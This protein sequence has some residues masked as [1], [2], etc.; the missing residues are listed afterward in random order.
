MAFKGI[1]APP[2][3]GFPAL[4]RARERNLPGMGGRRHQE[5]EVPGGNLPKKDYSFFF[6]LPWRL[7]MISGAWSLRPNPTM[8]AIAA[9]MPMPT[10]Q[11][12]GT[13]KT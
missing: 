6:I 4:V 10:P 7:S 1:P 5:R 11:A 13:T 2:G 12:I 8:I 3:D 9:P